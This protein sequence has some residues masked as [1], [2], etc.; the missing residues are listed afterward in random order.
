MKYWQS[1]NEDFAEQQAFNFAIGY[2]ME[3]RNHTETIE[4]DVL[5]ESLQNY[6]KRTAQQLNEKFPEYAHR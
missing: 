4:I 3:M 5:F 6:A 2:L 1:S